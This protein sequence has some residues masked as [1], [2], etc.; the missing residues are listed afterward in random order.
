MT[1]DAWQEY[2]AAAQR[3]AAV[4]REAAAAAADR[5]GG[6]DAV[7]DR[8]T[9]VRQRLAPQRARLRELGVAEVDLVPSPPE[10]SIAARS[11]GREPV[12]LSAA[13]D[14]ADRA[15]T[16]ADAVLTGRRGRSPG[17]RARRSTPAR[18]SASAWGFRPF[19]VALILLAGGLLACV[20]SVLL[21]LTG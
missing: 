18:P 13:L 11:A 16:G 2:L 10:L 6:S 1:G 17:F 21:L 9:E 14:Q 4:R 7:R 15:V 19:A 20:G 8:L 3:L 5:L 12:T